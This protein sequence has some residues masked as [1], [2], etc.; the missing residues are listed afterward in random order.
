MT[1][2]DYQPQLQHLAHNLQPGS[3]REIDL[4]GIALGDLDPGILQQ[5]IYR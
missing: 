2:H 4:I 5:F 1:I 3:Q